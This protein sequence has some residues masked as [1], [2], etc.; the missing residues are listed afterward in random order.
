MSRQSIFSSSCSKGT[1]KLKAMGTF[2]Y[3]YLNKIHSHRDNYCSSPYFQAHA[4]K[5]PKKAIENFFIYI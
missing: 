5:V 4:P 2:L 3:L 1:K